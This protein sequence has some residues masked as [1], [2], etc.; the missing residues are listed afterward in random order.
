MD[1]A[2]PPDLDP[3]KRDALLASERSYSRRWQDLGHWKHLWRCVGAH[4][5]LS[6]FEVDDTHQLHSI[7]WGLPM[8]PYLSITITPLTA[9]PSDVSYPHTEPSN[10]GSVAGDSS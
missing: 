7:L 8:F 10:V 6:I 4:A 5:N 1:V 2:L 9:H 3:D